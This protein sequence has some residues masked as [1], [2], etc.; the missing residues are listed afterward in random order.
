MRVA[1]VDARSGAVGPFPDRYENHSNSTASSAALPEHPPAFVHR[2]YS[3]E[4]LSRRLLEASFWM[5]SWRSKTSRM[6]SR[7]QPL[8]RDVI[9]EKRLVGKRDGGKGEKGRRKRK[10]KRKAKAKGNEHE[11]T[12]RQANA[13]SDSLTFD[14]G[15][16]LDAY[17]LLCRRVRSQMK[18]G[19]RTSAF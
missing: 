18:T 6:T 13:K 16:L 15:Q 5:S 11:S 19:G 1:P 17:P 4:R 8:C 3:W 14:A 2:E 9:G 10:Q 12:R 7:G